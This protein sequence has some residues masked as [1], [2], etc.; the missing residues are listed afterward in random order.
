MD[1]FDESRDS[2]LVLSN[3]L[4]ESYFFCNISYII[5]KRHPQDSAIYTG[6]TITDLKYHLKDRALIK[7]FNQD[8][9]ENDRIYPLFK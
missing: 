7:Y 6:L 2:Y 4:N 9:D 3:V 5:S 1:E 8:P